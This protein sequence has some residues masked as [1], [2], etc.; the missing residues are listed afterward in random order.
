MLVRQH[1]QKHETPT[2]FNPRTYPGRTRHH[3]RLLWMSLD[4]FSRPRGTL[5]AIAASPAPNLRHRHCRQSGRE[6]SHVSTSARS[7]RLH[8]LDGRPHRDTL[9]FS[10]SKSHHPD[11]DPDFCQ[12]WGG[13]SVSSSSSSFLHPYCLFWTETLSPVQP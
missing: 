2:A 5:G 4:S 1:Q 9:N 12:R 7:A 13:E 8:L 3:V 10:H 6:R 11:L